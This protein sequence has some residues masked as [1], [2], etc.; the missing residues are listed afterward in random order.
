MMPPAMPRM[1]AVSGNG[2]AERENGAGKA[3]FS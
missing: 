2:M 1:K 3:P